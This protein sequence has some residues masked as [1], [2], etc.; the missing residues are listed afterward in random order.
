M[1]RPYN[2][3]IAAK[4]FVPHIALNKYEK[5]WQQASAVHYQ[6]TALRFLLAIGID[7]FHV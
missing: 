6:R 1:K 3:G 7:M 4:P 5:R 2:V